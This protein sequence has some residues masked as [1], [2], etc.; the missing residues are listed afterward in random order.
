MQYFLVDVFQI[1]FGISFNMNVNEVVVI[2]V[3]CCLGGKVNLND[4]VNCGQ[5]SNDIIFLIIYISVV[6]EISE[7]LLLVLCYLEQIIQSKVGE[8]YVYV[9][10]GCIYLMD[11][12]L[13]CMSQVF[14]GWVQQV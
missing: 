1:G 10:I 6:F 9:K 13:V 12:M 8:V 3:S 11:V 7:C 5:S 4:Y 14:G 2:L